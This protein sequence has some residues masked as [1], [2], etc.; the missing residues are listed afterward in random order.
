M[1]NLYPGR[2]NASTNLIL[3]VA[4][5]RTLAVYDFYFEEGM[6]GAAEMVEFIDRVQREDIVICESVQRGLGS[7]FHDQGR[8]MTRYEKGIQHFE[9]LVFEA[10]TRDEPRFPRGCSGPA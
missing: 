5:D 1:V 3:P 10:L 4:P 9:R 8:L 7:G 6:A 2:G